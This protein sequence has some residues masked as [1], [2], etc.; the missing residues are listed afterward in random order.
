MKKRLFKIISFSLLLIIISALSA[1][2]DT[3]S[4]IKQTPSIN[5]SAQEKETTT[6]QNE[7]SLSSDDETPGKY[8][9]IEIYEKDSIK[10]GKTDNGTEVEISGD[11]FQYLMSEYMKVKGNNSDEEKNLLDKLQVILDNFDKIK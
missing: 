1:C 11:N 6:V 2:S 10:Y 8:S 7:E 4:D 9:D 5:S 3:K